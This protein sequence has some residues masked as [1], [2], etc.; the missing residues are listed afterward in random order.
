MVTIQAQFSDYSRHLSEGRRFDARP[1]PTHRTGLRTRGKPLSTLPQIASQR[2]ERLF[3]RKIVLA[4]EVNKHI[5]DEVKTGLLT[6]ALRQSRNNCDRFRLVFVTWRP[7]QIHRIVVVQQ[8]SDLRDKGLVVVSVCRHWL[9]TRAG[10]FD[11]LRKRQW[12]LENTLTRSRM[13]N[14]PDRL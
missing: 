1:T 11:V 3:R 6:R 10:R 13:S 4:E 8:F 9:T 2:S 7:G 14:R 5:P 12:L